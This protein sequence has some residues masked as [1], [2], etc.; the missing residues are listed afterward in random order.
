M[1]PVVWISLA[2]VTVLVINF[3]SV[4]AFR[5]FEFWLSSFKIRT[6]SSAIILLLVLALSRVSRP[7]PHNQLL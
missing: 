2:L 4:K 3:I 6:I 1:N 7:V 5:E